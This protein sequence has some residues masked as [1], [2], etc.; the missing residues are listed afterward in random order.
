MD[1]RITL[2]EIN[3]YVEF[4]LIAYAFGTPKT[5]KMAAAL[6]LSWGEGWDEGLFSYHTDNFVIP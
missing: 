3:A 5:M 2:G 4:V 6:P 1:T